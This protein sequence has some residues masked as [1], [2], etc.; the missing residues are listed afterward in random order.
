M[1]RLN[2]VL[3]FMLATAPAV[4]HDAKGPN[5][6]R[7]KDLGPFHAELTAKGNTVELYVELIRLTRQ[8]TWADTRGSLSSQLAVGANAS[9]S[10]P[11]WG[12]S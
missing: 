5:G 1:R 7:A 11:L 10:R 3:V 4:A 2:F 12:T 6:A 9:T 8:L